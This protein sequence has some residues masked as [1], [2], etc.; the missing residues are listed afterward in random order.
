MMRII[1]FHEDDY[2]QLEI[3][4]LAAKSFCLWQI[5]EIDAF[6]QAH[7]VGAFYSDVYQREKADCATK[8][9]K[10]CAAQLSAAL[11][12]LPAF[13]R[14]ETGYGAYREE[15]GATFA[16]GICQDMAVF[17]E[18]GEN[19]YVENIWLELCM[20]SGQKELTCRMLTVLGTLAP[21]LLADWGRGEC[22][23]LTSAGEI[24]R[25]WDI[26]QQE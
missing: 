21:L 19:G 13:D 15:C 17:W 1:Y 25:Y 4:P 18:T 2:L 8:D 9:L 12:F 26:S 20:D 23:D 24:E 7:R 6:A 10:L 3:L 22:V 5:G 11:S 16:R 14:V